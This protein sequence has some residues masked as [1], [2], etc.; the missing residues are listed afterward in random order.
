MNPLLSNLHYYLFILHFGSVFLYVD[1]SLYVCISFLYQVTSTLVFFFVVFFNTDS[2]HPPH[3]HPHHTRIH[4][5]TYLHSASVSQLFSQTL[6]HIPEGPRWM[7]NKHKKRRGWMHKSELFS[8]PF[9]CAVL[10]VEE[11]QREEGHDSTLF[12]THSCVTHAHTYPARLYPLVRGRNFRRSYQ[13]ERNVLIWS[14]LMWF[15]GI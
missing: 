7:E 8:L 12:P 4:T 1:F 15:V 6:P 14:R 2:C 10:P 13:Y 9:Y 11:L 3:S 5:L